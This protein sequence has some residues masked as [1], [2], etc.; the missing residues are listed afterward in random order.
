MDMAQE[1]CGLLWTE[2]ETDVLGHYLS[3]TAERYFNKQVDTWW[4]VLPTYP[5]VLQRILERLRPT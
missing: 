4:D 3:E 1:S 2:K 5:Y